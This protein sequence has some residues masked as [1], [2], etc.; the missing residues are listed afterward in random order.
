MT[1]GGGVTMPYTIQSAAGGGNT[2]IYTGGG[3]P[4][5]ANRLEV[6]FTA[7]G[8]NL[9][10]VPFT[11]N[12]PAYF[13]AQPVAPQQAGSYS[14]SLTLNVYNVTTAGVAALR[15][16]RAF[17]ATG[18]V[19]SACTIGGTY[20]P[21]A[22]TATIAVSAAGAVSTAPINRSFANVLCTGPA[23]VELS[24]QEGAVKSATAAPSGFVNLIDYS[25]SASFS[26]ASAAL[27]TA[28]IPGAT[29]AESG[30]AAGTSGATPNGTLSVTITP[31]ANASP[32][33]AGGYADVLRITI[34]P[35]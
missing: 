15:L 24:S 26:G 9:N 4:G 22:G 3:N 13:L 29:G 32:L 27:D 20:T 25:A 31:A 28:T 19:T 7:A 16:S 1:L 14:D 30:A 21:A 10:N 5:A 8:M 6:S 35:Q 33:V 11:V 23:N 2:L 17:T 12:L 34:E 18:T